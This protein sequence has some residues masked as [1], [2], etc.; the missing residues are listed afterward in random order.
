MTKNNSITS[1][2]KRVGVSYVTV[3]R[4]LNHP[5]KVK[6]ETLAKIR[7]IFSELDFKPRVVPNRLNTIC[8]L[9]PVPADAAN[10]SLITSDML[11]TGNI[12]RMLHEHDIQ[13]L[14]SPYHKVKDFPEVFRNRFI[15]FL[16]DDKHPD[17]IETIN[18]LSKN[19]VV[20]VIND[21]N[22][23]LSDKVFQVCS[24]HRQGVELVMNHFFERGH[25]KVAYIGSAVNSRGSWEKHDTYCDCME[26][27]SELNQALI[28]TNSVELLDKG[29][30][31]IIKSGA[32][33]IFISQRDLT[34]RVLYFIRRAGLTV[35]D[36]ISIIS[37]NYPH[38]DNYEYPP[39]TEII[40]PVD[41]LAKRAVEI[42]LD[43]NRNNNSTAGKIEKYPY[44]LRDCESVLYI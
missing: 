6:P 35:P 8:L 29:I 32:T 36:D 12:L 23:V 1:I 9:L 27:K 14:V 13:V 10:E 19:A 18:K 28:F 37:A 22:D 26:K 38:E 5:D 30:E 44:T 42:S 24:D 4:A 40:Q 43:Q 2:A 41:Q 25:R 31:R 17:C 11:I 39:L 15:S 34:S 3:S 16:H 7:S 33:A 20:T 21:T